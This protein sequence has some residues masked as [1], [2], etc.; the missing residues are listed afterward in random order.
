MKDINETLDRLVPEP[1]RMSD[2]EAVLR[3][4]RPRRRSRSLQL[5]GATGVV[6]L[7]ALFVVAPWKGSERVGV[8]DK[9]LA[10]VGDGPVL[11]VVIRGDWGGTLVDLKTGERS[12]LYGE[13]E[14]WYDTSRNLAH[15]ISRFG[16]AVESEETYNPD[17]K[18]SE[19]TA[20]TREY[21]RALETG[22]ARLAGKGTFDGSPVYWVTFR[23]LMLPDVADHRDHEFAEKVAV[24]ST[25]FEPV[26][27]TA[28][29]DG[30]VFST[31]RILKLETVSEG[32]FASD[33][34]AS[35]DGRAMMAGSHPIPLD[36][37]AAVLGRTPLWLGPT[38]DAMSLAQAQKAVSRTGSTPIKR[39]VT[40]ARA[41]QIRACLQTRAAQ[42]RLTNPC[43]RHM[44]AIEQRGNKVYELG[45]ST[46]GP[47]HTGVT[48]FYGSVGDDPSTFKKEDASPMMAEPHILVTQTTDAEL[49]L[50]AS[51]T[52]HYIPPDGS[53]VI[54]PGG[55]GSLIWDGLYITIQ[56]ASDEK[57]LDAARALRPMS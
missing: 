27:I 19:L 3:Q 36:T 37:A 34:Q 40:G 23:R 10:A 29:R 18:A 57:V 33:P 54:T 50:L 49:I 25:T 11:H 31:E 21:R 6:A 5:A 17:K 13:Q 9:A 55:H 52:M 42:T 26:G 51:R 28:S 16:G 24:S 2:W 30:H 22:T 35:P 56:A 32:N 15:E 38:Y 8:L 41:A 14:V 20:L 46:F 1:A 53:V 7:V 4:A 48:F 39:L 45:R 43:P 12:P 47:L 44:G